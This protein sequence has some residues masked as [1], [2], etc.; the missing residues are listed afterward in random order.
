[1]SNY[2][3][4]QTYAFQSAASIIAGRHSIT[5]L[6]DR[7]QMMGEIRSALLVTGSAMESLGVVDELT[8]QLNSAGISLQVLKGV[9]Q[10]PTIGNIEQLFS[11]I[12]GEHFDAL[13]GL[14]GGSILDAAKILSVMKTNEK[15]L[16]EML[17]TDL[18]PRRGVP[19]VLIPTT[20]GT[21]SEVTPNAIVTL[22][23]EE[24]KVGIISRYLLPQLAILD[25]ML[26]LQ[27]PKQITA[28][29]GMDAFTHAFESFISNK[30]NPIS[31]MFAM[32]S[33]R[34]IS[35]SIV[36]AYQDG[37]SI[38]ARENM[39]LGSMYGGMALTGA[40]TAAVHALAYPLGG[41]FHIPHGVANS[42]LLPHVTEFN[43]DA[44]SNRLTN[45]AQAMGFR[46]DVSMTASQ[47]A[48]FVLTRISE[49]IKELQIP[50]NLAEY[51]VTEADVEALAQAASKVTR[52]LNNNPKAMSLDH[53]QD[54]Y[55][56]L[57]P[58]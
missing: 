9:V 30:A 10:E 28:A 50:Q 27:L 20:S 13:I 3:A 36:E 38:E 45:V 40:G 14:G 21:G 58:K 16:R 35:R 54:V 4:I 12:A 49:W 19:L 1:M 25:P 53:I 8:L 7:L 2:A 31:D 11:S 52:L 22:P 51:G 42:M 23:E 6:R 15:P 41:K 34:R 55:K 24:L 57:L 18:I 26:T 32:E 39:L 47:A 17:G 46:H 44:I 29:T 48:D 5:T 37:G 43:L 56:K 33:I